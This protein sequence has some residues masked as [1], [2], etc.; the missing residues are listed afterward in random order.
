MHLQLKWGLI[1]EKMPFSWYQL[2]WEQKPEDAI[3]TQSGSQ[4]RGTQTSA[5]NTHT[6]TVQTAKK[7]LSVAVNMHTLMH[8]QQSQ[9]QFDI[10]NQLR[11]QITNRHLDWTAIKHPNNCS[12][13]RLLTGLSPMSRL[14]LHLEAYSCRQLRPCG[15]WKLSSILYCC[16]LKEAQ[17]VG[18]TC[19]LATGI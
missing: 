8:T 6:P 18:V 10:T 17:N 16:E 19:C 4:R 5:K 13:R 1:T 15:L 9:A 3:S 11:L 12:S 2:E 7:I 14:W